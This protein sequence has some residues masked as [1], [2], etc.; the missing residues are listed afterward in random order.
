MAVVYQE[1]DFVVLSTQNSKNPKTGDMVQL[2]ILLKDIA[3]HEAFKAAKN[4]LESEQSKVCS[5]CPHLIDGSCY[6]LWF[7]GPLSTWKKYKRGGHDNCKLS[8]NGKNIRFGAAGNPT[9]IPVSKVETIAKQ[10]YQWTGYAHDWLTCDPEYKRFFMASCDNVEEAKAAQTLGW[11]TFRVRKPGDTSLLP[12][13]IVCPATQEKWDGEPKT[14]CAKCGLCSGIS[15][16]GKCSVV[17]DA[18]GAKK[19]NFKGQII[20]YGGTTSPVPSLF[21][22]VLFSFIKT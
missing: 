21:H 15:G 6:V 1:K 5:Q 16:K 19:T 18:H 17:V 11:R 14:D 2:Y 12:N 20:E 3:P 22:F 9:K 7:Q 10:A 8:L 13:E 4:N